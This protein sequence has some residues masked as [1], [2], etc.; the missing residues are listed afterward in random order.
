MLG[1]IHTLG[2]IQLQ[3]GVW[4]L[5]SPPELPSDLG[6]FEPLILVSHLQTHTR[7]HHFTEECNVVLLLKQEVNSQHL[8]K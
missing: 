1:D 4:S 5:W 3:A 8:R 6:T 2:D 7:S